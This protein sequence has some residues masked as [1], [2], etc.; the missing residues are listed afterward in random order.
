MY[1]L[2]ANNTAVTPARAALPAC[3]PFPECQNAVLAPALAAASPK[4]TAI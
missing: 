2:R 3:I 4:A 1:P